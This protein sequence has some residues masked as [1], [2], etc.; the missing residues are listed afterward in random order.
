M[1]SFAR[2]G[3]VAA[4]AEQW[5]DLTVFGLNV[6]GSLL[7]GLLLGQRDRFADEQFALIGVGFAGGL[8]TFSNFAVAVASRLESGELLSASAY[9][10]FTLGAT[11]IAA[12]LGYRLSMAVAIRTMSRQARTSVR[13]R[14]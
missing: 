9:G 8:T 1:G 2:W 10:V 4:V 5:A 6:V 13:G 11:L 7:L 14:S 12:G 3:A